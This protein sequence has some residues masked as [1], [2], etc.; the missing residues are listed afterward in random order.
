[1]STRY[2]FATPG[3]PLV[4]EVSARDAATDA[5]GQALVAAVDARLPEW[6]LR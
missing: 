1:M 6:P 2:A 5:E 4:V 3:R